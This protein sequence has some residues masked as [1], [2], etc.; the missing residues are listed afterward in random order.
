MGYTSL[1]S[2]AL[3]AP[4]YLFSFI[5]VLVTAYLSDRFR[6]RS[7][8]IIFHALL[9]ASGYTVIAL[10]GAYRWNDIWRYLGVYP[11]AAGFFSAITI[12]IT[13]TINNQD[14]DSK[15]GTG[16]AM[17]NVIGQCGPLV[18]TR[19]YPDSD[20]PYYVR[21]MAICAVF[22][23]TV[24]ALAM[25][26]RVVLIRENRKRIG[27]AGSEHIDHGED[28]ELLDHGLSSRVEKAPFLFY[29]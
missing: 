27:N 29:V 23:F 28:V 26:L 4:P 18:G 15:K 1:K 19:L 16:M 7:T 10:A 14:S 3:S 17:L 25:L 11:A 22:M 12:I 2:Q 21:G 6:T 9:A 5:V 20:R 13:W 24:A 8:F